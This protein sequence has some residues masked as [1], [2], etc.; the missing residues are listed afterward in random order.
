MFI[1]EKKRSVYDEKGALYKYLSL[2][3][4]S[5]CSGRYAGRTPLSP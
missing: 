5:T 3:S 4:G 1:T 2:D